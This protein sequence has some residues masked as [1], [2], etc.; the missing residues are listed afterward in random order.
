M[1][2]FPYLAAYVAFRRRVL[3]VGEDDITVDFPYL[4]HSTLGTTNA[5]RPFASCC[6]R[7]R[8]NGHPWFRQPRR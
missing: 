6:A 1:S 3:P 5:R 8:G 2:L 4:P 7:S